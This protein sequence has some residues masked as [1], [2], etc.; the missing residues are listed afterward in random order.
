MGPTF[1]RR[2]Q[3]QHR[4]ARESGVIASGASADPDWPDSGQPAGT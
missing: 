3:E 4:T 2:L 1:S